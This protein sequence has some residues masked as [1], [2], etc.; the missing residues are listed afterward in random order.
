MSHRL[1]VRSRA[2]IMQDRCRCQ[3]RSS[4]QKGKWLVVVC[5][6][7]LPRTLSLTVRVRWQTTLR[8]DLYSFDHRPK[9]CAAWHILGMTHFGVTLCRVGC[10]KLQFRRKPTWATM[11]PWIFSCTSLFDGGHV[12]PTVLLISRV[13]YMNYHV[14]VTLLAPASPLV[15]PGTRYY[16]W[17]SCMIKPSQQIS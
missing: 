15:I 14:D 6:C 5:F 9:I 11:S 12:L 4:S 1:C 17:K 2:I 7:Y 16:K 3:C 13:T 8:F 10:F